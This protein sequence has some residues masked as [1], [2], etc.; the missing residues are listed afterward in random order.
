MSKGSLAGPLEILHFAQNAPFRMTDFY[1]VRKAYA[2]IAWNEFLNIYFGLCQRQAGGVF[3]RQE[4]GA[5][6]E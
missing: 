5:A 2:V 3:A 6:R 1:L 4:R